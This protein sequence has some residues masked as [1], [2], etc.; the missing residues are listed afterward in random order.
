MKLRILITFIVALACFGGLARTERMPKLPAS[1]EQNPA[2]RDAKPGEVPFAYDAKVYGKIEVED[3]PKSIV[4]EDALPTETPAHSCFHLKDTRPLPA[5]DKGARY[6]YPAYSTICIIPLSDASV[7][8]FAKSYPNVNQAAEKLRKLLRDR[9]RRFKFYDDLNE[10]PNNNASGA[11]LS[12]VE[13]LPFKTGK[14][15]LF[16]TQY[17]QDVLATPI[18]NEELTCVF[19][20]LSEDGKYYVSAR[21]A[22]T[23]PS[24]PKGIDF[25]SQIKTDKGGNYLKRA[26]QRLN[27]VSEGSF[28][29][30]LTALKSMIASIATK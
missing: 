18:N 1:Q 30:S 22:I 24:L 23:H 2:V 16:L 11:I 21:L 4:E 12:R 17:S 19:Q 10:L 6:F 20:G 26:E 27:R 13:Y 9:P 29:P 28:R 5:L 8:D 15:V 14:G 25:T 7:T 3:V